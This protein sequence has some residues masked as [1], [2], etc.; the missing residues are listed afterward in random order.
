M[1]QT[2]TELRGRI[3]L[4][5]VDGTTYPAGTVQEIDTSLTSLSRRPDHPDIDRLL[6]ARLLIAGLTCP[7]PVDGPRM[8]RT[9]VR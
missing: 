9:P 3:V 7:P 2:G 5:G 4:D 8:S 1:K 6:D